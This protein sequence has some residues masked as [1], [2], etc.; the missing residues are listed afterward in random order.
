MNPLRHAEGERC[1]RLYS[2]LP[3]FNNSQESLFFFFNLSIV[4]FNAV[5]IS[6]VQQSDPGIHT[7]TFFFL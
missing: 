5:P 3:K 4:D 7:Y 6:A 1:V 2:L